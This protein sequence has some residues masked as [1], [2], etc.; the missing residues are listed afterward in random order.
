MSVTRFATRTRWFE[1]GSLATDNI[2]ILQ[3]VR[4]SPNRCWNSELIRPSGTLFRARNQ[5]SAKYNCPPKDVHRIY[6]EFFGFARLISMFSSKITIFPLSLK[7]YSSEIKSG[8]TNNK[9]ITS[10]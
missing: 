4:A 9:F 10:R 6:H 3:I 1:R 7:V 5:I 2:N 8:E